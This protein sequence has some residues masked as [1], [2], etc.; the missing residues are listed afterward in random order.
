MAD[1]DKKA[2]RITIDHDAALTILKWAAFHELMCESTPLD[3]DVHDYLKNAMR[4]V[5]KTFHRIEI[6][7]LRKRRL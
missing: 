1:D 7:T 4:V 6:K 3:K 2:R 5:D